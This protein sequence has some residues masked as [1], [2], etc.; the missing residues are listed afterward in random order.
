V[1]W[2]KAHT[3]QQILPP[4]NPPSLITHKSRDVARVLAKGLTDAHSLRSRGTLLLPATNGRFLGPK[5]RPLKEE[6]TPGGLS[7]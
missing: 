2:R 7:W 3:E 4:P 6:F 1:L 5:R